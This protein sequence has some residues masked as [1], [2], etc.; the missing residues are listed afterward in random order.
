MIWNGFVTISNI[1]NT[2]V[3]SAEYHFEKCSVRKVNESIKK[4]SY[5]KTS[6]SLVRFTNSALKSEST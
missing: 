1:L 6:D 3:V 4:K 2:H 5:R